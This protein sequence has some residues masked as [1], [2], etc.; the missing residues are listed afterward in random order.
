MTI[1]ELADNVFSGEDRSM[2]DVI[3]LVVREASADCTGDCCALASQLDR[4]AQQ[5]VRRLWRSRIKTFVPL[6][7]LR[8]V[9]DCV[10]RG[11]CVPRM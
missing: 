10:R 7:A 11:Y 9:Q 2:H 8:G 5:E 1:P 6:L 3:R 4:C